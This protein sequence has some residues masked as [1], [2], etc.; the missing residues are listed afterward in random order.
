MRGRSSASGE[1]SAPAGP[2]G[3]LRGR[4]ADIAVPPPRDR[5]IQSVH[6]CDLK[7]GKPCSEVPVHPTPLPATS[8]ATGIQALPRCWARWWGG[9][10]TR[11]SREWTP[12]GRLRGP[13]KWRN[14]TLEIDAVPR[15]GGLRGYGLR[16]LALTGG[17]MTDGHSMETGLVRGAGAVSYPARSTIHDGHTLHFHRLLAGV[18]LMSHPANRRRFMTDNRWIKHRSMDCCGCFWAS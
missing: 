12:A 8:V 18:Y 10:V 5:A 13:G 7:T 2:I 4:C 9:F 15:H 11:G 3:V 14:N 1:A 16:H 6:S 17:R